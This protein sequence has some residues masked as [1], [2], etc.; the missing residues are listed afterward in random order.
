MILPAL[1]ALATLHHGARAKPAFDTKI[2]GDDDALIVVLCDPVKFRF[3]VRAIADASTLD[4]SYPRRTVI[5]SA[6]LMQMLPSLSGRGEIRGPLIRYVRCGPYSVKLTGDA[7]N[8]NIQGEAGAYP[9]FAAA[10]IIVGN[11]LVAGPVRLT[12]CDRAL[13]R[14]RG[15]PDG[16]AVRIDGTYD[17]AS[18]QLRLS[19][20]TASTND[21]D[22][23]SRRVTTATTTSDLDLSA[24][25][26]I[27]DD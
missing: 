15:C 2:G 13:P 16:Y 24:W 26:A 23:A 6:S 5:A 10:S 11:E 27:Y 7:Y 3:S 8:A 4:R 14:A 12:E 17:P 20:T 21:E 22:A 1:L 9:D 18:R 19:Q 25:P